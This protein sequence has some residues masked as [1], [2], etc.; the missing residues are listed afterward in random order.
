MWRTGDPDAYALA[1]RAPS[2]ERRVASR[3]EILQGGNVVETLS[4]VDS[5]EV[6]VEDATTRRTG[7]VRLLDPEGELTP[8]TAKDLLAPRGTEWRPWKGLQLA[9]QSWAWIPLGTLAVVK[10]R[11]YWG[12]EG[13]TITLQGYDRSRAISRR[14]FVSPFIVTAGTN[15]GEAIADII[16]SRSDYPVALGDVGGNASAGVFDRLS[17]P[18]EA[19]QQLAQADGFEAYFD[20]MGTFVCQPVVEL[21]QAPIAW[22]Y[23]PGEAS[24]LL[25]AEREFDDEH[26]YSGVTVRLEHPDEPPLEVTVWDEDPNS[27]TYHLG[28]FGE[29]PY[30]FSS[31][32]LNDVDDAT[33][34][35]TAILARVRGFMEHVAIDTAGHPGHEAGDVLRIRHPRTRLDGL[36]VLSRA[37]VPIRLG[38]TSCKM[39]AQTVV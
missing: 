34:A 6:V 16:T 2:H 3:V 13:L 26:T 20:P 4:S 29:V 14:R 15:F 23:E 39:R 19:V 31:P 17:N 5:G 18:W 33:A 1:L 37:R 32:L 35:A 30:G 38:R 21:T 25:N 12:P 7:Q 11:T 28:E 22:T 8:G 36:Y 10:P 24:L 9:D 27:P